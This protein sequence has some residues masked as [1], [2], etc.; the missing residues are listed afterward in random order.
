M[1]VTTFADLSSAS[2]VSSAMIVFPRFLASP[3]TLGRTKSVFGT[4]P[5]VAFDVLSGERTY[6]IDG[7]L[8]RDDSLPNVFEKIL[9]LKWKRES[10]TVATVT[11]EIV[12]D[13]RKFRLSCTCVNE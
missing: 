13:L 1:R 5:R 3:S 4:A 2:M 9:L 6:A 7:A 8:R 10:L 12:H 11:P